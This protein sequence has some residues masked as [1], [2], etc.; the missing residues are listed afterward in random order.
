ME[1]DFLQQATNNPMEYAD[2]VS[3]MFPDIYK[4]LMPY[5]EDTV[6]A[7][8]ENHNLTEE[9]LNQLTYQVMNNSNIMSQLP[10]GHN[11]TTIADIVKVL[12]LTE[13]FNV[14]HD[15][16]PFFP[17]VPFVYPFAPFVP[18][19]PFFFPFGGFRG[20]GPRRGRR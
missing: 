16:P 20:R 18:I 10:Y 3:H 4:R 11:Q 6:D 14:Y 2:R 15:D 5:I 12:L 7:L 1:T 13:I 19:S 8:G 9:Q 17:F